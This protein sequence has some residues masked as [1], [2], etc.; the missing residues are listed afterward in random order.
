MGGGYDVREAENV[1]DL[2][3]CAYDPSCLTYA[4]LSHCPSIDNFSNSA[5]VCVRTS[6][7]VVGKL[8][9]MKD[10]SRCS[11]LAVAQ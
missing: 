2:N 5:C 10:D 4:L 8:V 9:S 1:A 7:C 11:Q 3:S 6:M